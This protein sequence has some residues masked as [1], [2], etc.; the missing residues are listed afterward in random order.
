MSLKEETLLNSMKFS[1]FAM[2][3]NIIFV[4]VSVA[5]GVEFTAQLKL[6]KLI[7]IHK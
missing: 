1:F 7:V 6:N 5:V 4:V 2:R 3:M